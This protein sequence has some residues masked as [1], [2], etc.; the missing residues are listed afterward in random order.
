LNDWV[1]RLYVT[2]EN[3]RAAASARSR[4]SKEVRS[5]FIDSVKR[6]GGIVLL[7]LDASRRR[8]IWNPEAPTALP[9][10]AH[11]L[12]TC[13]VANDLAEKLKSM[14]NELNPNL[15]FSASVR[16]GKNSFSGQFGGISPTRDVGPSAYLR[17]RIAEP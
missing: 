17:C 7:D 14:G 11:L 12:L 3:F 13:M 1:V 16:S 10:L 15:I 2:A 5:A 4:N 9:F 6:A 8:K